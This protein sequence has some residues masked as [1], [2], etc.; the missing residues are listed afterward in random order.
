MSDWR[1]TASETAA[2]ALA[3]L[4]LVA[5]PA[6]TEP[7]FD[8]TPEEERLIELTNLARSDEGLPP[9][10]SAPELMRSAEAKGRDMDERGYFSH[11]SPEGT[12]PFD[13]MRQSGAKFSSAGENIAQGTSVDRI[14]VSWMQSADH[15][16]NILARGYTH[17][18]VGVVRDQAGRLIAVQHFACLTSSGKDYT[19]RVSRPA[20]EPVSAPVT[21]PALPSASP[22]GGGKP[23]P[24]TYVVQP[25]DTLHLIGQ[26]LGIPV[27]RLILE[28][29]WEVVGELRPGQVIRVPR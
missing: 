7:S 12:S 29:M 28:N 18:G 17:L 21:G 25:G 5:V 15:R 6:W 26:R 22:S 2:A 23:S 3:V 27:W 11:Y 20:V 13:L 10:R 9:L 8:V 14:F 16:E 19:A 1:A 4:L 24:S